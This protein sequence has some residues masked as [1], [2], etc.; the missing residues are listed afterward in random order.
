MA[1]IDMQRTQELGPGGWTNGAVNLAERKPVPRMEDNY[2]EDAAEQRRKF[3]AD[4]TGTDL[5]HTSHYSVDPADLSGNTENFIGVVQMPVGVAGP[6]FVD[7][8][9]ARGWFYVPMATTEIATRLNRGDKAATA[10]AIGVARVTNKPNE[11][12]SEK[13]AIPRINSV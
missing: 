12:T 8:E 7:G 9:E 6:M 3:L 10:P 2:T 13:Q 1:A 11:T 5:T 4:Q